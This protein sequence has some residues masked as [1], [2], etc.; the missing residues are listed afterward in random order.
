MGLRRAFLFA[1]GERYATILINFLLVAIVSR[2][3][4]PQEI[5]V[6]VVGVT[7]IGFTESIRDSPSSYLVQ[8]REVTRSDVRTAFTIM[9]AIS[10][11]VAGV[12]LLSSRWL[13]WYFRQDGLELFLS[14]IALALLPA[15][16]ER[17]IMALLR[18]E[19]QFAAYAFINVSSALIA[20]AVTIAIAL[21][22][23]G[24]LCFAWGA[25]AGSSAAAFL[26][27][28]I[29]PQPG[30]FLPRITEARA[31]LPFNAYGAI[32][33]ALTAISDLIP[34]AILGRSAQFN[35]MGYFNRSI[36]LCRLP[37]KLNTGVLSL[38]LPAFAAIARDGGSVAQAYLRS[39]ELLTVVEWPLRVLLVFFAHPVVNFILGPQWDTVVPLVQIMSLAFV[40][41]T[42]Q[43]LTFPVLVATG[44]I[45]DTLTVSLVCWPVV[46][47]VIGLSAWYGLHAMALAMFVII[48]LQTYVAVLFIRRRAHFEWREFVGAL[49]KSAVVTLVSALGPLFV[50]VLSDF[51]L[52]LA[53]L[54]LAMATILAAIGWFAGLQLT[55]HP[56]LL[57]IKAALSTLRGQSVAAQVNTR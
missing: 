15:C 38:A 8:K 4:T 50:V 43:M 16:I 44:G 40:M 20:A 17:P 19:M 30:L 9:F 48:P 42:P 55:A 31:I 54:H 33:G 28:C 21:L 41:G 23:Y 18:R 25:L 5:G 12:V 11:A 34:Y 53:P 47:L 52:D 1:S 45:R 51:K 27:L 37:D 29:R 6:S 57:E 39:V 49:K 22:G 2:L 32:G 14:L 3:L 7:I 56:M 26:A 46:A 13:T 36:T 35:A 24:Y 10:L